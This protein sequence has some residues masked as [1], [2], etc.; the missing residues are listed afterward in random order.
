MFS[1]LLLTL[2]AIFLTR[3]LKDM[4]YALRISQVFTAKEVGAILTINTMGW[5]LI[6]VGWIL[7][8]WRL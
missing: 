7:Y 3:L 1:A 6:I 5:L 4:I 2:G 8:L